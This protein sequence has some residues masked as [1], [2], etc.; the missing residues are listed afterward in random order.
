MS[1]ETFKAYITKYS[2]GCGKILC[3]D[4]YLSTA[5]SGTMIVYKQGSYDQYAHGEGKDW[6]ITLESAIARAESMKSA[7]I[8]S[9]K[10][11][12]A[13]LESMAFYA[14]IE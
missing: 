9:L 10:K 11:S 2:L 4:A 7:K 8:K 5:G 1:T 3:V 6:H 13:K 12:I 14:S